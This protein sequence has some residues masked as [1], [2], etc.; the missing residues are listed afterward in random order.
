MMRNSLRNTDFMNLNEARERELNEI[1]RL[2]LM[3]FWLYAEQEGQC[4]R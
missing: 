1:I 2:Q 4:S 3:N